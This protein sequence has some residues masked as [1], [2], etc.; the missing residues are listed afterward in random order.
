MVV[1]CGLDRASRRARAPPSIFV[2]AD[3]LPCLTASHHQVPFERPGLTP[4]RRLAAVCVETFMA[5]VVTVFEKDFYVL[6]C[7]YCSRE[8]CAGKTKR[9]EPDNM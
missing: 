1:V 7:S 9:I 5:N 8:L 6:T 3:Y 2:R 4:V